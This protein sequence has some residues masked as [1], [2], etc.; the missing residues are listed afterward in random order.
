MPHMKPENDPKSTLVSLTPV[1]TNMNR[2]SVLAKI[3]TSKEEQIIF[4]KQ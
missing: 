4:L 2:E 3:I 1:K